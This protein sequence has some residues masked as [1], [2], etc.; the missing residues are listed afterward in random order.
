M[1]RVKQ[2]NT[3]RKYLKITTLMGIT[4]AVVVAPLSSC[5]LLSSEP[6]VIIGTY[7]EEGS[8]GVYLDS[9]IEISFDRLM[10]KMSAQK[11]FSITPNVDGTFNWRGNTMVFKPP[12]MLEQG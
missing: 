7:P 5:Q 10:N 3:I 4:S 8:E 9:S 12:D 6:P 2:E 1:K 11:A